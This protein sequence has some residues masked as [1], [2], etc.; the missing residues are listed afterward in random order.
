MS[1]R[2][3]ELSVPPGKRVTASFGE[4]VLDRAT[5]RQCW[6]QENIHYG[7]GVVSPAGETPAG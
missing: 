3:G 6:S 2:Q 5:N 7:I 4:S 1:R